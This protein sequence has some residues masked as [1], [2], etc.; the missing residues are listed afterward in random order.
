ML[1]VRVQKTA[2]VPQLQYSDKMVDV[3]VGAVHRRLVQFALID[4]VDDVPV[5][6]FVVRVSPQ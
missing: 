1:G 4:K 2:K 5:V 6:Q 3:P